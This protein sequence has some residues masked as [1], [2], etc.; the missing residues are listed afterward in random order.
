MGAAILDIDEPWKVLARTKPYLLAPTE[1]YERV[2][3]VPNVT[4]P[5]AAIVHPDGTVW[6]YYGCADTCVGLATA[7][8]GDII[9]FTKD[10]SF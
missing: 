6:I 7:T 5:T 1:P 8:L 4:F 9:A 2:G 3:D 10:N